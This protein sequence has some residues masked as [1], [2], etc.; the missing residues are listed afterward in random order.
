MFTGTKMLDDR[1]FKGLFS[2]YS[3]FLD[4]LSNNSPQLPDLVEELK[5]AIS[6]RAV[7][8]INL[9]SADLSY[10]TLLAR[11]LAKEED[12]AK[13][14]Q[15]FAMM[16]WLYRNDRKVL[17][18][19]TLYR[20][21]SR[22]IR[23]SVIMESEVYTNEK[24]R[25]ALKSIDAEPKLMQDI[26]DKAN[27][28]PTYKEV[29]ISLWTVVRNLKSLEQT[30]RIARVFKSEEF[31]CVIQAIF[32]KFCSVDFLNDFRV[33]VDHTALQDTLILLL[34]EMSKDHT[35]NIKDLLLDI[36][37]TTNCPIEELE[38]I[39]KELKS[40][41]KELKSIRYA[42][43]SKARKEAENDLS[44]EINEVVNEKV[45]KIDFG[46]SLQQKK[47][48]LSTSKFLLLKSDDIKIVP[49]MDNV[50]I[51]SIFS[52][53]NEI[54]KDDYDAV[55]VLTKNIGHKHTDRVKAQIGTTPL[56]YTNHTNRR[57]IVEDIYNQ[58]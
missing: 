20:K 36:Q 47:D 38:S 31:C 21:Q 53:A 12:T 55:V 16:R 45:Y 28:L 7:E 33:S 57:L 8:E 2:V 5:I 48:L 17:E 23:T 37:V 49:V 44:P 32:D 42:E 29:I 3:H 43:E 41:Y 34:V 58:F 10:V 54:L 26:L 18:D 46:L 52:V 30:R 19:S 51:E 14:V 1:L 22:F 13:L 50:R 27:L 4:I 24:L 40:R 6:P 25:L 35:E 15:L 39:N 11:D 56:I 9:T